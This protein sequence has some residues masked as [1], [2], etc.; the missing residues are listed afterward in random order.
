M[1][2]GTAKELL[3]L[4]ETRRDDMLTGDVEVG[5]MEELVKAAKVG[6]KPMIKFLGFKGVSRTGK[7]VLNILAEPGDAYVKPGTEVSKNGAEKS[8]SSW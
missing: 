7:K 2:K 6:G 3:T 4:W 1:A 5:K 8:K